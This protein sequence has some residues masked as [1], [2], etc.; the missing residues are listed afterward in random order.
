M[1]AR[2]VTSREEILLAG[3]IPPAVARRAV[4]WLVEL[5]DKPL[6]VTLH[7]EW[8]RWLAAH[9]DH[10]RAWRRIEAVNGQLSGISDP[11]KSAIARA[12]LAPPASN[13]RRRAVKSLAVLIFAGVTA[14]TVEEKTP[15]RQLTADLRTGRGERKT[16][17]LAD[18][19]QLILN[20]DT[21]VSIAF[22][23]EERR[24]KLIAGEILITT[25]KDP[26]PIGRPFLVE[27]AQGQAKAL[28]TYYAVR[29]RGDTTAVSVFK[30]AVEIQP[31]ERDARSLVIQAGQQASFTSSYAMQSLSFADENSIAWAE[32]FIVARSMRLADF[33]AE[34]TRYSK[35]PL[36][37]DPAVA[38]LRVSGSYPV[39]DIDKVLETLCATLGLELHSVTRFWGR[40]VVR[41]TLAP[42]RK[43]DA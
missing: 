30:G 9:P 37:C 10:E 15:W 14:W 42:S 40:Q 11:L 16:V 7:E 21:A 8:R 31:N 24:I 38:N 29:Q 13:S 1:N 43:A 4:E 28:G 36:T 3:P 6:S 41:V 12:T 19:T 23:D 17:Q 34:L 22:N 2:S 25:A 5:Q 18:G 20:T 32:G 39:A 35:A 33:I 26:Q 27:S